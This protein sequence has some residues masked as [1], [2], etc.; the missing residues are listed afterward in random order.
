MLHSY[1]NPSC[2]QFG[3]LSRIILLLGI[4]QRPNRF[5]G[6]LV[7]LFRRSTCQV[8]LLPTQRSGSPP[9]YGAGPG[10]TGGA[11]DGGGVTWQFGWPGRL[12]GRRASGPRRDTEVGGVAAGWPPEQSP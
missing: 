4:H 8:V 9:R 3:T 6:F 1:D 12:G 11:P 2:D 7:P 10:R 5:F